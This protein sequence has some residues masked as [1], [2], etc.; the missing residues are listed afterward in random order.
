LKF[1]FA[2]TVFVA[3]QLF[4]KQTLLQ[5]LFFISCC[6]YS[7]ASADQLIYYPPQTNS[8]GLQSTKLGLVFLATPNYFYRGVLKLRCTATLTLVY[9]FEAIEYVIGG[10]A[11][12]KSHASSYSLSKGLFYQ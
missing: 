1:A 2:L 9:E 11:K 6:L 3:S 12:N 5:K 10:T 7:Q 4:A 8:D